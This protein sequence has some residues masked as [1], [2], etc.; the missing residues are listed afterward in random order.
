MLVNVVQALS[1][2]C[3]CCC[4]VNLDAETREALLRVMEEP[5]GDTFHEAQ[6]HVYHLMAKD[7][8]PRFLRSPHCLEALRVP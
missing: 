5:A 7:S 3:V 8:Y 6:H 4:Q 1:E 2:H